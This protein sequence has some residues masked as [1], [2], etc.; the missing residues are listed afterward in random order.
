MCGASQEELRQHG[1]TGW[2]GR[3][4]LSGCLEEKRAFRV[5]MLLSGMVANKMAMLGVTQAQEHFVFC[6]F[7]LW[8]Y[9][10]RG[11]GILAQGK[12]MHYPL[13]YP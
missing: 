6:V 2:W 1:V 9:K 13:K 8:K 11:S 5:K 4:V 12:L 3:K 10:K 7:R